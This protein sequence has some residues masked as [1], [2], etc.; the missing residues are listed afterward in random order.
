ML[1]R[2]RGRGHPFVDLIRDRFGRTEPHLVG[3]G[4]FAGVTAIV[5][6]LGLAIGQGWARCE[7]VH[8]IPATFPVLAALTLGIKFAWASLEEVMFRGGLLPQLA[9]RVGVWAGLAVTAVLFS[10]SHLERTGP[11]APDFMTLAVMTLNGIGFALAYLAT[12]S[13]W[14]PSIWHATKN[15]MIWLLYS[16]SSLQL[17]TGV[18]RVTFSGPRL[19][20]GSASQ[21]GIFD[22]ITTAVLVGLVL[23]RFH[24]PL[25]DDLDWVKT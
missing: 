11:R 22:L 10:L 6:P 3:L 24:R 7:L 1:E 16:E 21:A 9:R 23:A 15:V 19:W 5:L 14:L 13:L 20:V 12:R 8:P 4:I 17:T 18:A 25:R 2:P